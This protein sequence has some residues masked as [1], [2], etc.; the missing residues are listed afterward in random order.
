MYHPGTLA[1]PRAAQ[2]GRYFVTS[3]LAPGPQLTCV[4]Y[5]N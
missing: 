2:K 5:Y 4:V 1:K 3:F